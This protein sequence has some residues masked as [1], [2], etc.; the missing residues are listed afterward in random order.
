MGS[1]GYLRTGSRKVVSMLLSN[2]AVHISFGLSTAQ[3]CPKRPDI[4]ACIL[5]KVLEKVNMSQF[6]GS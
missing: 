5:G 2:A 1:N 6:S 3:W 4:F